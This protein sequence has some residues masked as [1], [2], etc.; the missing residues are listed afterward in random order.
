[1][2]AEIAM[3]AEPDKM[4]QNPGSNTFFRRACDATA[5]A[6]VWRWIG[7]TKAVSLKLYRGRIRV[8]HCHLTCHVFVMTNVC[9]LFF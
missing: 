1:M 5:V 2:S 8:V 9:E 7:P 6:G 3:S 4:L